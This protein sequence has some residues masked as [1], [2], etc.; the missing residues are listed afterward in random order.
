MSHVADLNLN[1]PDAMGAVVIIMYGRKPPDYAVYGTEDRVLVQFADTDDKASEQRKNLARLNPVRG[2]IN[3]L[4]DG[5]RRSKK[6]RLAAKAARYDRRVGDALVVAFEGDVTGAEL[7]LREIKQNIADERVAIARFW[8]LLAA[9]GVG[10]VCMLLL[11]SAS[12]WFDPVGA[13]RDLFHA[14]MTGAIGAF[15]SISL[16]IRSRT[17]LPDLQWVSNMMDAMLRIVIGLIGG[18]VLM[19]LVAA[20]VVTVSI[21]SAALK[22]QD[23]PNHW[24][25]ALI[26]GFIAGFSERFVPDLLAKA[27]GSTESSPAP[28]PAEVQRQ[29]ESQ[30]AAQEAA[31]VAE[32]AKSEEALSE[33]A[34]AETCT[35]GIDVPD[36]HITSDSE[37]PPASGGV[38]KA[39][40]A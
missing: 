14:A 3:G 17:V 8:Y 34:A 26:V 15:F 40:A 22:A 11:A 6:P 36:D 2:E 13:K 33:E 21:G 32:A 16:A 24:L 9:F 38:A 20:D 7:L 35:V 37:L 27:A 25:F 29:P 12:W 4:I 31:A 5:W 30:P 28:K 19:A 23:A 18:G 1:Q 10:V 39:E